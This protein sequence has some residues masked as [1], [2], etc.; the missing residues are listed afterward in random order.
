MRGYSLQRAKRQ[1]RHKQNSVTKRRHKQLRIS[2]KK[3][4]DEAAKNP[5][6]VNNE[7][8]EYDDTA[9]EAEIYD[10]EISSAHVFDAIIHRAPGPLEDYPLLS[11][12]LSK[13]Y[14]HKNRSIA[15]YIRIDS[16]PLAPAVYTTEEIQITGNANFD[17]SPLFSKNTSPMMETSYIVVLREHSALLA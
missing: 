4:N 11:Q 10:E 2:K 9:D 3:S 15:P 5:V 6:N 1:I 16:T 14:H 12:S 17:T 8:D 13:P 7:S